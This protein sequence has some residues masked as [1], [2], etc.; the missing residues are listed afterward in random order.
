MNLKELREFKPQIQSLAKQYRIDP[1]SIRVFGSV[2]H[3][4]ECPEDVDLLV[5]PLQECSLFDLGGF[6]EDIRQLLHVVDVVPDDSIRP[7]L[8]PYI[9]RDIVNL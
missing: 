7:L 4:D 8:R 9:E 2:A 3:G 6:Y 5:H 1:G